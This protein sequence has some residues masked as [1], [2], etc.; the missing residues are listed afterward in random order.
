MSFTSNY[1][2]RKC[3]INIWDCQIFEALLLCC[4]EGLPGL[5]SYCE[6]LFLCWKICSCL[7]TPRVFFVLFGFLSCWSGMRMI[8]SRGW[9]HLSS[10]LKYVVSVLGPILAFLDCVWLYWFI[11]CLPFVCAYRCQWGNHQPALCV[12]SLRWHI[13]SLVGRLFALWFLVWLLKMNPQIGCMPF[14]LP[15]FCI[16]DL[17]GLFH[18]SSGIF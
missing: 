9:H 18:R 6:H 15:S 4:R 13:F 8:V 12:I 14:C 16:R 7:Y 17:W 10:V 1:W 3:F 2:C 5:L 11:H